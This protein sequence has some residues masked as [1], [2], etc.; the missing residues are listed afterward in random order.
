[1][2]AIIAT[3]GKQ[4]KVAEND[5]IKVDISPI[6]VGKEIEFSEVLLI[7]KGDDIVIG[8][9]FLE[10]AKVVGEVIEKGRDKKI[11]I[12]K[13][14]RRKHYMR[15]AGHRQDFMTVKIKSIIS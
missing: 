3:S 2:Y 7:A 5:V 11:N 10:K 6:E 14:R 8:T 1:M 13:F 4:Y 9:P 12:I 15:R